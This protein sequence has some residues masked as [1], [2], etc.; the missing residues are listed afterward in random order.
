MRALD[1][2][3]DG[4]GVAR[5]GTERI[6]ASDP[7]WSSTP[8][9]PTPSP[10]HPTPPTPNPK[11]REIDRLERDPDGDVAQEALSLERDRLRWLLKSYLRTRLG[12]VQQYA[13]AARDAGSATGRASG[14]EWTG[15]AAVPRL[16]CRTEPPAQRPPVARQLG[17]REVAP[18]QPLSAHGR[19]RRRRRRRHAPKPSSPRRPQ[20][21]SCATRRACRHGSPPRS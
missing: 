16:L 12:K 1:S 14:S 4:R 21:W 9:L 11:E 3:A 8:L 2:G 20:R 15:Q 6:G 18:S 17:G 7:P 10:P 5:H 19:R 13:G